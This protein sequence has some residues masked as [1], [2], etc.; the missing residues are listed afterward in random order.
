MFNIRPAER[1]QA[2]LRLAL[3]GV[4]GSGKSLGAINIASGMGGK[5]VV[6]DTEHKSADLY[7]NIAKYDVLTL[8]KP[9]TPEKYIQAIQYCEQQGYETIIVDSLSHAWAGEGGVLDMHEAATQASSSKNSYTAWKDVTP[10]QNKLVNTIIQ[11]PAHIITTLR[12]K[13]HHDIVDVGGKKRPVKIGLAPIQKEGMEYEFTVVLSLD[14]DSYLYTSS[15]DR[16]SIFEGK[17]EK[18]SKETG[19]QLMAWLM[20]GK[21]QEDVEREEVEHI[22]SI[23]ADAT[24]VE[25]LRKEYA[26]AKHRFPK[27]DQEFLSVSTERSKQLTSEVH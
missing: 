14:K 13:T 27:F 5:F 2:K 15:K 19:K 22:K 11:S 25:A 9:F 24:T 10:W 12:V 23:L 18:L 8:D 7:A 1:R 4:S 26:K 6:I 17:H 20:D 3:T 21:S 16:T